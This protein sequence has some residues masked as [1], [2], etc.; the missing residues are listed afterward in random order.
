MAGTG[1]EYTFE[2]AWGGSVEGLF[3][4]GFSTVGGTDVISGWPSDAAFESVT[5]DVVAFTTTR[6]R[7]SDQAQLMTGTATVRLRDQDGKYNPANTSSSLYPNVVPWRAMRIKATYSATEYALFYG[8]ITGITNDPSPRRPFTALKCADLLSWLAIRKPTIA[9]TGTTTTGGAIGSI[10]DAIGWPVA[11][12]NLDAGDSISDFS[13]DGT[14]TSL[15][16]V[17]ELLAAEM[18][19]FLIAG[20]GKATFK[21]RWARYESLASA[22][23]I[24]GASETLVNFSSTT[25]VATIFNAAAVT[26]TGGAE[27]TATDSDSI[28]SYGRRD[29]GALTTPYV[30]DNAAALSRAKLR[31]L[32][33][34][35]PLSPAAAKMVSSSSTTAA[36]LGRELGDRVTITEPFGSTDQQYWV[37]SIAQASAAGSGAQQHQTQWRLSETPVAANRIPVI[38]D[39]TGIGNY[40]AV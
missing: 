37:E 1:I 5:D 27:Q 36:M 22:S 30:A 24:D 25:A 17:K 21:N 29:M 3:R 28:D 18:G 19:S 15:A 11:L 9:S 40:I 12:R 31:V 4:I 7:S 10:L 34:K 8:F 26:K 35:D 13:A 23:T 38:I 2:V 32:R 39:V 14:K 20:D 6:G 33:Y 16:L